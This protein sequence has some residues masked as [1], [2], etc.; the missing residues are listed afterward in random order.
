MKLSYV[1]G[2]D[3]CTSQN[4]FIVSNEGATKEIICLPL[5]NG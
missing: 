3:C 2:I 4:R 5:K 1:Y